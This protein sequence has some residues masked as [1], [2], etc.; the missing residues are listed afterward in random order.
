VLPKKQVFQGQIASFGLLS[1]AISGIVWP[2]YQILSP[3]TQSK[4]ALTLIVSAFL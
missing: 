2:R 4:K 1:A 3:A